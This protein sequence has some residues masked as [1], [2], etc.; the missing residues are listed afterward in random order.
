VFASVAF[1]LGMFEVG[2]RIAGYEAIFDVYSRPSLFWTHDPLLGWSHEP[3][4]SGTYVGPRPWP[5][6][7][8]T[9]IHINSLG[10]R[11]PELEDPG[12]DGYRI[13]VLGDSVVAA[14]EVAY[15]A[16]FTRLVEKNL[17][18][19]FDFPVQVINAGV[20]GYGT[21]QSYLYY[22]ERG[23]ALEPDLVVFKPSLNDHLNNVTLHRM[24]RPFGKAAFALRPDGTLDLVGTPIPRYP[25][26][27]AF[28]LDDEYRPFRSDTRFQRSVC[29]LQTRLL[30]HSA[31]LTFFT[32]RLRENPRLL[33]FLYGFGAPDPRRRADVARGDFRTASVIPLSAGDAQPSPASLRTQHALTTALILALAREV[34]ADGAGFEL[35]MTPADF[36]DL[37]VERMRAEGIEPL[38]FEVDTAPYGELRF[39][40]DAHYNGRGHLLLS[41]V[42]TPYFSER[43]RRERNVVPRAAASDAR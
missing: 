40:H 7:F 28:E 17:N 25:L 14:F 3:G 32:I 41:R 13:L 43:I 22:R 39:E 9:P 1:T 20:R 16:T 26:C 12:P 11:G 21:D 24:R 31:L 33:E 29:G 27:S 18:R 6:E 5:I 42:L 30:D 4:A 8:K 36:A 10:L 35:F 34:R 19:E 15:E 2:V 23:R 38:Y 37:E